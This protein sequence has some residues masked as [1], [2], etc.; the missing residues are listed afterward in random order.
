MSLKLEYRNLETKVYSIL[1]NMVSESE[2]VSTFCETPCLK[3]EIDNYIEICIIHDR[4]VFIDFN[5]NS[6]NIEA[7]R[8]LEELI[9]FIE[10][11]R[12]DF[13]SM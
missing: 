6:A 12:Q 2:T 4:L 7:Y 8:D 3:V 9:I 1:R 5:G 13:K 11:T 10:N